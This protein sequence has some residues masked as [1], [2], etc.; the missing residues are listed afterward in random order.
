MTPR[1]AVAVLVAAFSRERIQGPTEELYVKSLSD[2]P[3]GLLAQA[4]T[5]IVQGSRFFPTVA[6]LRETA[7]R[8]AGLL[9]ATPAE[10]VAI[11]RRA[12]VEQ[13]VFRRDGSFAYTERYW[14]W[15]EDVPEV[16]LRAVKTSLAKVGDPYDGSGKAKFGWDTG[17]SKTYEI[18]AEEHG[19]KVLEDIGK[20]LKSLPEE[21]RKSL[22]GTLV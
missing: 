3:E 21:K 20:A 10:A 4:V 1:E 18:I 19:Q 6:E 9:P 8:I 12:D 14:Q 2:I 13:S 5:R 7:A 22:V 17:F 16:T 11:V 15:P